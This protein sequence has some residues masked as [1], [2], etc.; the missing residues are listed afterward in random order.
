MRVV[1]KLASATKS[2]LVC[3]MH[4]HNY[5]RAD[6]DRDFSFVFRK[7]RRCGYRNVQWDEL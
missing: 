4:G 7:C 6:F 1:Q 5:G 2:R 3:I